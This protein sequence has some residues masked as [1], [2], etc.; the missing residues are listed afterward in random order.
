M[1]SSLWFV[2]PA[3]QRYELSAVCFDQ[4]LL[5]MDALRAAGVEAQCVVVADDENLDLARER[6]FARVEQDNEWLRRRFND[7]IEYAAYQGATR[8]VPIGSDSWID[9][10]Y[11]L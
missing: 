1:T 8:I 9:P 5:V 6:G 7:G 2:T 4:R 3:W 11:L 10:D